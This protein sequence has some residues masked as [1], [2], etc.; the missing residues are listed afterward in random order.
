MVVKSVLNGPVDES[1]GNKFFA[2]AAALKRQILKGKLV[3]RLPGTPALARD[4]NVTRV[5]LN[6]ALAGCNYQIAN[7]YGDLKEKTFRI[8]HMGEWALPEMTTKLISLN[9]KY[10]LHISIQVKENLH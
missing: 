1:R 7:G 10:K 5:T 3:D 4:F 6:K 2:V 8:G 9:I